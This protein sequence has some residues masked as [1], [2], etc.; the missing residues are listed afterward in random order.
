MCD[1]RHVI[2]F[3]TIFFSFFFPSYRLSFVRG[4]ILLMISLSAIAAIAGTLVSFFDCIL[5]LPRSRS[6]STFSFPRFTAT[7]WTTDGRPRNVEETFSHCIKT[8]FY[9][10]LSFFLFKYRI[11]SL[12]TIL[13]LSLLTLFF[14]FWNVNNDIM[15]FRQTGQRL[16]MTYILFFL[17]FF[18]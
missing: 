17:F 8:D 7:N 14:R 1:W 16:R 18:I 15:I 2:T 3:S 10:S 4:L 5:P 11:S 6:S 12:P 13:R 9:L